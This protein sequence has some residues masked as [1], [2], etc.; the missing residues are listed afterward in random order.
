MSMWFHAKDNPPFWNMV[1]LRLTNWPNI[2]FPMT[3]N[4]R[5]SPYTQQ[6]S[7]YRGQR[8]LKNLKSFCS[9]NSRHLVA[10]RQNAGFSLMFHSCLSL[11][12]EKMNSEAPCCKQLCYLPIKHHQV[13][14][15]VG[16]ATA[17]CVCRHAAVSGEHREPGYTLRTR[18]ST[19][20]CDWLILMFSLR[21]CQDYTQPLVR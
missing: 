11:V 21:T 6:E 3:S 20:S 5:L 18:C 2:L 17:L 9:H 16:A 4:K 19:L 7:V 12:A 10:V 1:W 8:Y 14:Q 15:C 13:T